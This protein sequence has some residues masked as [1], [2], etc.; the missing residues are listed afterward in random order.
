MELT[1]S[2]WVQ[3]ILALSFGVIAFVLMYAL[4]SRWSLGALLLMIPFQLIVSK[5]GSLN[6]ILTYLLGIAFLFQRKIKRYPLLGATAFIVFAYLLALTQAP[7]FLMFDNL[8]YL[9]AIGSNFILFYVVYNYI[10]E[11]GDVKYILKIFVVLNILVIVYCYLQLI[12]GEGSFAFLGIQELSITQNR[13][14]DIDRRLAGPF[15][16]VGITAEYL[17]IQIVILWYSSIYVTSRKIK[18]LYFSLI[19]AN[20]AFLVATGNRGGLISLLIGAVMLVYMFRRELGVRRIITGGMLAVSA[21]ILLSIVV[22]SQTQ[23]DRL[24]ERVTNTEFKGGLPETRSMIWPMTIEKIKD[25]PWIGHAPRVQ[26]GEEKGV[27]NRADWIIGYP[28]NLYL[29][30]LFSLGIVGLIAYL[31]FWARLFSA[32]WR[33]RYTVRETS[34]ISGIPRLGVVLMLVILVDQMKVEFLRFSLVDYQHY[35]FALL[36]FLLGTSALLARGVVASNNSVKESKTQQ[37][38]LLRRKLS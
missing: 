7:R 1:D 38:V 22:V 8:L 5:Y 6:V 13:I 20:F 29:F 4:P 10:Q 33:S 19:A 18:Y 17:V 30:L 24:Y 2:H 23:F 34:L 31:I 25:K 36:A 15:A 37:G 26:Y 28:H 35:I 14:T 3:L 16:A 12:L 21:F 11:E 32:I 27:H 9:V